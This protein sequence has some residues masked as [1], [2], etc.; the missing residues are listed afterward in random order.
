MQTF[1]FSWVW[2]KQKWKITVRDI[3][4]NVGACSSLKGDIY[5]EIASGILIQ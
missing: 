2:N 3:A 5:I 4:S 1:L